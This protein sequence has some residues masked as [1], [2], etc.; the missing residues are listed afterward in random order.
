[1]RVIITGGTGL[2]GQA[3]SASLGADGHEVI[4]LSRSPERAP[5]MPMGVRVV[6]WDARTAEGWGHLADGAYAIVNLA[7]ASLRRRWTSRYKT[8]IRDSRLNAGQAVFEAVEGAKSRPSVV[9][10]AAGVSLYGPRGDELITEETEAADTFLGRTAVLWEQS[11]AAV[12]SFG[13]RRAIVRSAPVLTTRG[14]VL[15]LMMLPFR[16]FVGGPLGSGR[17]WFPW[18]HI[19]DEVRAIHFLIENEVGVGPFN[20]TAP[21]TVTNAEFGRVLGRV[22]RR[23]AFFRV[24]AFALRF[25]LGEMSTVV[26][27]GQRAVPGKLHDLAFTFRFPTLEM[28]LR[29]LLG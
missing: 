21:D 1:M 14:G 24:P 27:D 20:L 26:L 7:G 23:P 22:V 5:A 29:D 15:P 28:A 12:E 18:I 16:L 2:I 17:Q 6:S 8:V 10:Q 11:T 9:V 19:E 3:L 4:V 25:V 13:V